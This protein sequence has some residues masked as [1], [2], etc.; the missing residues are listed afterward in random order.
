VNTY[1]QQSTDRQEY[2]RD[3]VYRLPA[4]DYSA[5]PVSIT[6]QWDSSM[7]LVSGQAQCYNSQLVIPSINFSSGYFPT[8][9]LGRDYSLIIGTSEYY[10]AFRHSNVPHSSV[11]LTIP[12]SAVSPAGSG[13]NVFV[14]LPGVTGWLDVGTM[15]SLVNFTGNDGDGC[16]VSKSGNNYNLTFGTFSTDLSGWMIIVKVILRSST[17]ITSLGTSW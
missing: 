3:E 9:L 15:F 4:G 1:S 10:R 13:L 2:F 6:S 5:V 11:T 12:G 8:Q 16:L 14:K 7:A 17:Y